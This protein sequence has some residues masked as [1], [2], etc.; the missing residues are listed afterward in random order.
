MKCKYYDNL[1]NKTNNTINQLSRWIENARSLI[2]VTGIARFRIQLL[3]FFSCQQIQ[4]TRTKFLKMSFNIGHRWKCHEVLHIGG[5]YCRR[6][7]LEVV[8]QLIVQIDYAHHLFSI[9]LF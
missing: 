8:L 5:R 9:Y 4:F 2:I 6:H 3:P 7:R 1:W